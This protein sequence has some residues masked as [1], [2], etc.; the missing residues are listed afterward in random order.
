M[1]II[2][3]IIIIIFL[4]VFNFLSFPQNRICKLNLP[5]HSFAN[6][7]KYSYFYNKI[8]DTIIYYYRN[9]LD[10]FLYSYKFIKVNKSK[11]YIS[12]YFGITEIGKFRLKIINFKKTYV[13]KGKWLIIDNQGVYNTI[14][15]RKNEIFLLN[16]PFW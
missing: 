13:K 10:S 14:I 1:W 11:Y 4:S 3:E 9:P 12:S 6:N 16:E 8:N 15:Y 5:P 2:R 7:F